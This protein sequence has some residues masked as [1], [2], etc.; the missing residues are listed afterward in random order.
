LRG[1]RLAHD[2]T[3]RAALDQYPAA[4]GWLARHGGWISILPRL[5]H[6]YA[7]AKALATRVWAP[8]LR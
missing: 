4:A 8:A 5:D 6:P 7:A 2:A 1:H 3:I